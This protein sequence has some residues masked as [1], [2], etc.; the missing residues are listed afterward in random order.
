MTTE[1]PAPDAAKPNI[2]SARVQCD[3]CNGVHHITFI[4]DPVT[5]TVRES[6]NLHLTEVGWEVYDD[7]YRHR[8][9]ACVPIIERTP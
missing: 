5:R 8:C 2:H 9:R 3:A 1:P 7:G 6:T 4:H